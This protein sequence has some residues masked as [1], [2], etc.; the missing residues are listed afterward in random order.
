MTLGETTANNSKCK[1][2]EKMKRQIELPP[3]LAMEIDNLQK[4]YGYNIPSKPVAEFL[5][6]TPGVLAIWRHEG[7]KPNYCKFGSSV[8]YPIDALVE[9]QMSS[10]VRAYEKD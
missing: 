4:R 2:E 5:G 10:L 7:R 9:Y 6:T 8:K 1:N 3:R